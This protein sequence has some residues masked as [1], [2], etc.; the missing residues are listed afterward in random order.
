MFY[1]Y[2]INTACNV[3]KQI[4]YLCDS[5]ITNHEIALTSVMNFVVVLKK[6]NELFLVVFAYSVK[7]NSSTNSSI[8]R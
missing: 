6:A 7:K 3:T 4:L 2:R 5:L 8:S 1:A